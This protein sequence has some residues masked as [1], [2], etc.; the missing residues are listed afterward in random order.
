MS[1]FRKLCGP[2]YYSNVVLATTFWDSVDPLVGAGRQRQLEQDDSF[3]G[4]LSKKGSKVCKAGVDGVEGD[5]KLLL[6][7]AK[8]QTSLL[9]AQIE[10]QSGKSKSETAAAKEVNQNIADWTELYNRQ[11]EGEKRRLLKEIEKLSQQRRQEFD[12]QKAAY[13][14]KLRQK[15]V[16]AQKYEREKRSWQ[17][18][19]KAREAERAS[20]A[21]RM[22]AE[23]EEFQRKLKEQRHS[24]QADEPRTKCIRRSQPR[25]VE[26]K[27]DRCRRNFKPKKEQFYRKLVPSLFEAQRL[28]SS[29]DCC[30]CKS[31]GV[32]DNYDQCTRCGPRC[33]NPNHPVMRIFNT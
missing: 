23:R 24:S 6:E 18:R 4:Q 3:W 9:A 16:E 2:N 31:Q 32:K 11:F 17:A 5:R 8:T 26:V 22:Q 28:I 29:T 12:A 10:M 13:E 1:M 33:G 7:M 14:E 20:E 25:V 27:C 30:L 21:K 15:E 19:Q